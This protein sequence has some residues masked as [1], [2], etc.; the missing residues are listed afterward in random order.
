MALGRDHLSRIAYVPLVQTIAVMQRLATPL[1]E[2]VGGLH[3]IGFFRQ[4]ARAANDAEVFS[5]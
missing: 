2:I 3:G 5:W 4:C 1:L